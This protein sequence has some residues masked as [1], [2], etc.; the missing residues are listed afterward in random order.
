MN[1]DVVYVSMNY[2]PGPL[3]YLS[4]DDKHIKSFGRNTN[5]VTIAGLS[6]GATCVHLQYF[7]PLPK[8]VFHRGISQGG[9]VIAPWAIRKAPL[10]EAKRLAAFIVENKLPG[11]FIT[12]YPY[13]LLKSGNITDAPWITEAT[14]EEGILGIMCFGFHYEDLN[15]H[16]NTV[17]SYVLDYEHTAAESDKTSVAQ[18]IKKF[19]FG[20]NQVTEDNVQSLIKLFSN[21]YFHLDLEK[22]TR[23]HAKVA[24]SPVYSYIYR[25]KLEKRNENFDQVF[26]LEKYGVDHT[27]DAALLYTL[28][29]AGMS[30][31]E[32]KFPKSDERIKDLMV[33]F[34]T[35][36]AKNEQ[37]ISNGITWEPVTDLNEFRYLCIHN[38]EVKTVAKHEL[39]PVEFWES[40]PLKKYDNVVRVSISLSLGE[41]R[42]MVEISLGKVR[43][44]Y[45]QSYGGRKFAAFEGIPYAKPPVDELRFEE[46]SEVEPWTGIWEANIVHTC[47]HL[48]WGTGQI[49]GSE[50]CLYLNVYVPDD[51]LDDE[52]DLDVI[53]HTHAGS[54]I[55][56]D[57]SI[58]RPEYLMD[59]NV[60]YVS[61][62]YRLGPL[63]FLSTEDDVVSGNMGLKDQVMALRWVQKHITSFG[64]NLNSVTLSGVSAGASCAHFHYFSPLSRGLFHRGISQ[65]GTA[66]APWALHEAPL[67][68]AKR[69]AASIGCDD[70]SREKLISCLK[71]RSARQIV[72]KLYDT[73]IGILPLAPFSPVVEDE[74]PGAFITDHP[75]KLLKSGNIT[76]VPWIITGTTEEGIYGIKG[77]N[78]QYDD[79][80]KH[81]NTLL[82][83]VLDYIHTVAESDKASVAQKIKKFYL[84]GNEV[85][86]DNIQSF[87]KLIG[88][89]Y[90]YLSLEESARLQAKM[91]KSPVYS[92]IYGYNVEKREGVF[93][94]MFGPEKY[95][96]SHGSD[97]LMVYTANFYGFIFPGGKLS[98][99]D[100]RIKELLVDFVTSFAKDGKPTSNG[101]TWEPVIDSDGFR[102]LYIDN[103]EIEMVTKN[104]LAPTE[105][106]QSLPLKEYDNIVGDPSK[107]EL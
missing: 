102:Y 1:R 45:L 29:S 82:P 105:F 14:T 31:P 39:A 13:R 2:R 63:G 87:I 85:T 94:Q 64:G 70:S 9:T 71:R 67:K 55:F 44:H 17:L 23:L 5:P 81:W 52:P 76:D 91:M 40:L 22:S 84:D 7:F 104:E 42:P 26:G 86:E 79:L 92:L 69:L 98:E 59:R 101:I 95:G 12:D 75:H 73:P 61:M 65:G 28:P 89:R 35:F 24:K 10:K 15:E 54:F 30:S 11:A 33:D 80:N 25:Y 34:V 93:D 68:E 27:S 32:D 38:D 41:D 58:A 3:G 19:Y 62:S 6:S 46:P 36:F 37:P 77:L 66:L 51:E 74:L 99:S 103:D 57:P 97:T 107:D 21:R 20:N 50:D 88:D 43:G 90:F 96:V 60:V 8:G 18:E 78:Y 83:Y 72:Q 106:W 47:L 56:G 53:V 49:T 100:E 4:S 48:A 16:W